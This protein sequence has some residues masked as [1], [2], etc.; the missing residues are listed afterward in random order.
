M[1]GRALH[2]HDQLFHFPGNIC[3]NRS[4]GSTADCCAVLIASYRLGSDGR[5]EYQPSRIGGNLT[6][7]AHPSMHLAVNNSWVGHAE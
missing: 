5:S 4:R 3:W 1:L 7:T 6:R 2:W